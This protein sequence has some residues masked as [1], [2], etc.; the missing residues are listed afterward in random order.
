MKHLFLTSSIGTP[1]VGESIRVKLGHNK[2]LKT[3]FI[4]T[5]VEVEDM[6]DDSWYQADRTALTKNGFDFFDYTV[7]SKSESDFH[8]D[9][10]DIDAIYVSGGNTNHLLQESHKSKFDEFINDFVNSGKIYV[11]TSAGSIITGS[12]LPS[13]LWDDHIAVPDLTDYKCWNLVN[14][15]FIPHWGSDIFKDKYL[16]DRMSQIYSESVQPFV[17]CNDHEYVEVVDDKYRII[18]VRKEK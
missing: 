18:D 6:S 13:Y 5:T 1:G 2:P 10:S 17:I 11:S 7:T 9:L 8:H 16:N 12:Q 4:T 3:A 15:T 14:F